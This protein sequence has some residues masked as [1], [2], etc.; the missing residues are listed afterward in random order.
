VDI[1]IKKTNRFTDKQ[2]VAKEKENLRKSYR[3]VILTQNTKQ[4]VSS[5]ED[6]ELEQYSSEGLSD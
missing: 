2:S 4:F 6:E 3:D 5:Q 1:L